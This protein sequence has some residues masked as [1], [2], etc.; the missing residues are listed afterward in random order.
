M[1]REMRFGAI[2]IGIALL[3]TQNAVQKAHDDRVGILLGERHAI[4]GPPGPKY[5]SRR[6]DQAAMPSVH[7]L[8]AID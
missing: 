2:D 6:L 3:T 5:Q 7:M 4:A 1:I 8:P